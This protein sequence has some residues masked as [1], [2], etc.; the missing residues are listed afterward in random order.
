[1]EKAPADQGAADL[2]ERL[3]NRG[4]S[5]VTDAQPSELMQPSDAALDHP[6]RLAQ[7]AAVSATALGQFSPYGALMQRIAM[8]LSLI[9]VKEPGMIG[10]ME[11]VSGAGN[12]PPGGG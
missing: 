11:P 4:S 2:E 3:V 12:G 5:F 10:V 9:A 7:A 1:M 8:G 6:A